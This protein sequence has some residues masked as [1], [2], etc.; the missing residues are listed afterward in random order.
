[1]Y[2]LEAE[3]R[4]EVLSLSATSD[5]VEAVDALQVFESTPR[6]PLL[7]LGVT[8]AAFFLILA[9]RLRYVPASI[10]SSSPLDKILF[11]SE[12]IKIVGILFEDRRRTL[13]TLDCYLQ[14]NLANF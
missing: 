9:N 8:T 10:N 1:M 4:E 12:G 7:I 6:R 2:G 5:D 11:K 3:Q 14:K 13:E